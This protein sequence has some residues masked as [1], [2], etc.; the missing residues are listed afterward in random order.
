MMEAQDRL[1]FSVEEIKVASKGMDNSNV[2]SGCWGPDPEDR[3]NL[4]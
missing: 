3:Y 4:C 1:D 2:Q